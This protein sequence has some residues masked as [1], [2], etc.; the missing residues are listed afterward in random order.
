MTSLYYHNV[1]VKKDIENRLQFSELL[2]DVGDGIQRFD[3][4]PSSVV[5]TAKTLVAVM[6][7]VII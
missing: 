2:E 5:R 4:L 3:I 1:V 7:C 6:G